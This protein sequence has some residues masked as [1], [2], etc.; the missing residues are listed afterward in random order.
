MMG[1]IADRLNNMALICLILSIT[2]PIT[3]YYINSKYHQLVDP[4]WKKEND[5]QS[6]SK[7]Q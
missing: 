1:F 7:N 6:E 3:I 2:V 4:K 5:Q